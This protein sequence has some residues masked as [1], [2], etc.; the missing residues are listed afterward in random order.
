MYYYKLKDA[1]GEYRLQIIER[2][3]EIQI[4]KEYRERLR[5]WLR[6]YYDNERYSCGDFLY[7]MINEEI[8]F[9][10]KNWIVSYSIEKT[11]YVL[12]KDD[13]EKENN[14]NY[15]FALF[16]PEIEKYISQFGRGGLLVLS[17]LEE[18]HRFFDT[19]RTYYIK[20]LKPIL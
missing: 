17:N 16:I 18:M 6:L 5:N 11:D 15:H 1:K 10:H 12:I 20:N 19:N 7:F 2:A 9:S 14:S 13:K 8:C 3:N 4:S